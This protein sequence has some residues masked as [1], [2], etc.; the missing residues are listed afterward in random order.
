[1]LTGLFGQILG[2]LEFTVVD[3]K[4]LSTSSRVFVPV[5]GHKLTFL[6][7]SPLIFYEFFLSFACTWTSFK[8]KEIGYSPLKSSNNNGVIVP[9]PRQNLVP[10][11]GQGVTSLWTLETQYLDTEKYQFS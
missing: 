9:K 10:I 8:S 6:P 4:L 11:L 1:M 5:L 3:P 2:V 7:I